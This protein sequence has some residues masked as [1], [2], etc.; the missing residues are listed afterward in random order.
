MIFLHFSRNKTKRFGKQLWF[1]VITA[2]ACIYCYFLRAE[3]NGY[4]KRT[5]T[6]SYICELLSATGCHKNTATPRKVPTC[7][8]VM[9]FNKEGGKQ[10]ADS[11]AK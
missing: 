4:Q 10:G 2:F 7:P 3:L 1:K 9:I 5:K 8:Y 6:T 11:R